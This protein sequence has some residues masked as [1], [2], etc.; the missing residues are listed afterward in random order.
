MLQIWPT[1]DEPVRLADVRG[2]H[3]APTQQVF[4]ELQRLFGR[5]RAVVLRVEADRPHEVIHQ[6]LTNFG[7]VMEHLDTVLRQLLAIADARQ[8]QQLRNVDRTAAQHN[9]AARP[10]DLARTVPV[11]LDTNRP[12]ALDHHSARGCRCDRG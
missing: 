11:E 3:A 10:H 7:C 8:H 2:E 9:L 12:G 1:S 4:N 6:V 5:E